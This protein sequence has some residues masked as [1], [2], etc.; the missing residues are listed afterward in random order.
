M[1]PATAEVAALVTSRYNFRVP[2]EGGELLFNARTGA[3]LKLSGESAATLAGALSEGFAECAVGDLP[4]ELA[5][6]LCD[7]GFLV[8]AGTDELV[9]IRGRFQQAR[10]RSPVVLTLT[11]TMDCNL[12]CYYCYESRSKRRLDNSHLADILALV[13][14]GLRDAPELGLHVDWYG[15][16]PTLNLG[17]IEAA[18]E[19]LQ[20]LCRKL[21]APYSASIISNGTSWP[22]DVE[23]FVRRHRIRQAQ[24]SFDGLAEN[25]NLR[26]RYRKGYEAAVPSFD[27]AVA[28]VDRL[29]E[30]TRVDIRFNTDHGNAGDLLPFVAFVRDRGWFARRHP[31]VI[32][33]A[34]LAN[35]SER[36]AFMER[37]QLPLEEFDRLRA[38][39]RDV[40]GTDFA[41]EES[42][43]PDG[44]P[45]PRTS[46]CAALARG[47]LVVGAEGLQY[48]C[49]LQVGETGR[50]VGRVG[51][52]AGEK[53][54]DKDWWE[55]F[56]PT[57]QPSCSR[58]S[59]LP[60]CWGGCP[61]KHLEK[62]AHA[63]HE[64]SIFWRTNLPRLV[65]SRFNLK[66]L[67]GFAY[68]ESDQFR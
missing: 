19:A 14:P 64:T 40:A 58:C 2:T 4:P 57:V 43:A 48:R 44:F 36:S 42:E 59:F 26:R 25:H 16:E 5:A 68:G 23:D 47:S 55:A 18:S 27:L 15:G 6:R 33:P 11:T 1:Q 22:A 54:A 61:K 46:V 7:G 28:L 62:D 31:A 13:E 45:Y 37:S 17:F 32:Q 3:V 30:V 50:A 49:G 41:I 56:D 38:A 66:P 20:G 34:R 21:Q 65:A 52:P 24:I 12:G 63:L 53:F 8:P 60:V 9:E 51:G 67:P 29:L 39:L 35:Y 10:A